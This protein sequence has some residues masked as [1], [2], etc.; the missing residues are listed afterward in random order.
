M[1]LPMN[2]FLC[3]LLISLRSGWFTLLER[4]VLRFTQLRVG[5][6]KV[7]I[8]GFIMPIVDFIKLCFKSRFVNINNIL[9]YSM[10]LKILISLLLLRF[11]K[12]Y[13]YICNQ[14]IIFYLM[15]ISSLIGYAILLPSLCTKRLYRVLGMTRIFI[16]ILSFEIRLFLLIIII[17]FINICN[18]IHLSILILPI[19]SIF[20]IFIFTIEINRH[21]F[22]IIEGESELVSGFNVELRSLVFIVFFLSEIINI[23][24][25]TVVLC[26]VYNIIPIYA[27]LILVV[28]LIRS[29]YPR[30]RYDLI[31]MF[32][33]T[34]IYVMIIRLYYL[35]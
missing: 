14:F 30:I 21:P 8:K 26:L 28:L 1:S 11:T 33:W 17:S 27:G 29:R 4:K 22:E 25:I 5:P 7:S 15:L 19:I 12:Y 32:Q 24:V 20:C 16:M 31:M 34:S 3:V 9:I 10:S 23:T 13:D 18:D 35:C 2:I 6:N